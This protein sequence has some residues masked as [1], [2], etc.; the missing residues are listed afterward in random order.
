MSV[1]KGIMDTHK[2]GLTVTS[3]GEGKGSTFTVTLPLASTIIANTTD[4]IVQCML[5]RQASW[6][7]T[8]VAAVVAVAAAASS[9]SASVHPMGWSIDSLSQLTVVAPATEPQTP[10]GD[11]NI[12]QM[13]NGAITSAV[14]IDNIIP[15]W[16]NLSNNGNNNTKKYESCSKND[17]VEDEKAEEASDVLGGI[18][19]LSDRIPVVLVVDVVTSNRKMLKRLLIG[20]CSC[21]MEAEDGQ[22]ALEKV[23]EAMSTGTTI[24]VITM[25]Y[26]MPVMDGPTATRKIRDLGYSGIIL[27]VTGNVL[28]EDMEKFLAAGANRVLTKPLSMAIFDATVAELLAGN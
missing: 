8:T 23:R 1:S 20:R 9:G 19:L 3:D 11:N 18:S 10:I 16:S 22:E 15:S 21:T 14:V 24:D 25:D 17:K 13:D 7:S 27:G 2:G 5:T 12:F 6:T 28:K 26:Q 4:V